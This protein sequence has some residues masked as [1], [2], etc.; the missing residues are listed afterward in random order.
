MDGLQYAF[1][2]NSWATR[3]LIEACRDLTPE[4]L[5]A[6]TPGAM[7]SVLQTLQHLVDT[8]AHRL[9][10][11]LTGRSP[12]WERRP[13]E[14]PDLDTLAARAEENERFWIDYLAT[15]V[16]ADQPVRVGYGGKMWDVT[17]GPILAQVVHHGSA[18]REQVC[19]ILTVLGVEPPDLSGWGYAGAK[20]HIAEASRTAS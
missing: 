18:H 15:P 11:L 16:D 19:T 7:G 17:A 5:A 13:D 8:E 4:Q 14:T 6:T 9:G 3:Q 10:T 2:H 20:G 12:S 1:R